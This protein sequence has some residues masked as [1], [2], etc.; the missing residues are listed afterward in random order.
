MSSPIYPAYNIPV[1]V[2]RKAFSM[3]AGMT[4]DI[5]RNL[6]LNDEIQNKQ[7]RHIY[8]GDYNK[9]LIF[10]LGCVDVFGEEYKLYDKDLPSGHF[11]RR[12]N[13]KDILRIQFLDTITLLA[14]RS[15]DFYEVVLTAICS[16][17]VTVCDLIGVDNNNKLFINIVNEYSKET[18]QKIDPSAFTCFNFV[19]HQLNEQRSSELIFKNSLSW[20]IELIANP[21]KFL[22]SWEYEQIEKPEEG[23]V[24]LY[25]TKEL[26]NKLHYGLFIN[27]KVYSKI[28][29]RLFIE[30]HSVECMHLDLGNDVYFFRKISTSQ[31]TAKL[32]ELSKSLQSFKMENK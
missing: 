22:K 11:L 5:T 27:G 16:F 28:G 26:S 20:P 12:Q 2:E 1:T 7:G 17:D 29:T 6:K 9:T 15:F 23:S 3:T 18:G 13:L 21:F 32:R 14:K 25:W 10:L 30:C 24:V 4:R 31:T 8:K 19:F